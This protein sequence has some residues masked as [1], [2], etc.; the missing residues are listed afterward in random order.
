VLLVIITSESIQSFVKLIQWE[1]VGDQVL[2]DKLAAGN[3]LDD[4]AGNIGIS[5]RAKNGDLIMYNVF[6]RQ[7]LHDLIR[8]NAQQSDAPAL[9]DHPDSL[10]ESPRRTRTLKSLIYPQPRRCLTHGLDG[11]FLFEINQQVGA[12]L[13][14]RFQ[15]GASPN[16]DHPGSPQDTSHAHGN[17]SNGTWANDCHRTARGDAGQFQPMQHDSSG[18][19]QSTFTEGDI[20]W[21]FV[22]ALD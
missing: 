1:N 22:N 7:A 19:N 6:E 5:S 10:I 16:N 12:Q 8:G 4:F 13:A 18:V 20:R 3:Q 17:Q 2:Y 11:V 9:F 15:P 14:C 21:H